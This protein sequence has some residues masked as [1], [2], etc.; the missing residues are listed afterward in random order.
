MGHIIVVEDERAISDLIT[1]NLKLVGHTYSK[2]Y[3][4]L[5][6]IELLEREKAD[7]ILL[8][9]MLPEL[10]GFEIMQR[11][12]HL[13]IPVILITAK[14]HWLIASKALSWAPMIILLN[15]LKSLNCWQES[16]WCYAGAKKA[17]PIFSVETLRYVILRGL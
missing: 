17:F 9:I 4:G 5:E 6:V 11:I 14:I 8:D 2:A 15:L 1:M 13:Q 10:D 12:A 16:M 3:R 7:L